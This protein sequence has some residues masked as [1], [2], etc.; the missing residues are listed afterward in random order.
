MQEKFERRFKV[1]APLL[2]KLCFFFQL[3]KEQI[4]KN[5]IRTFFT[6]LLNSL[7]HALLLYWPTYNALISSIDKYFSLAGLSTRVQ[8]DAG[9]SKERGREP[10]R[11]A[12]GELKI[13]HIMIMSLFYMKFHFSYVPCMSCIFPHTCYRWTLTWE[14]RTLWLVRGMGWSREVLKRQPPF[15]VPKILRRHFW[16]PRILRRHLWVPRLPPT[17]PQPPPQGTLCLTAGQTWR[18]TSE[19]TTSGSDYFIM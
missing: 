10:K 19:E 12:N 14:Y 3:W 15:W 17:S 1:F 6:V 16:V 7:L 2:W 4:Q 13:I 11:V 18:Q 5:P 9:T 8:S